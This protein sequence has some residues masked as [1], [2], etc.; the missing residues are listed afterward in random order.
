MGMTVQCQF[1]LIEVNAVENESAITCRRVKYVFI[2][3]I[4][5]G[6]PILDRAKVSTIGSSVRQFFGRAH[7]GLQVNTLEEMTKEKI[8]KELNRSCGAHAPNEYIFDI[9]AED[10]E[11]KGDHITE[12]E[13]NEVTFESLWEEFKKQNSPLN[14]ILFQLAKDESLQVFGYGEKGVTE[15]VEKLDENEVLYG[16]FRVV[17]V[18][19]EGT[20]TSIRERFVFLIWVPENSPVFARARVAMHKAVL[21]KRLETY[22]AEIRAEEKGDITK[23]GLVKLLDNTCGSHKPQKYIFAPGDEVACNN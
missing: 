23:E 6:T 5:L 19:Q 12:I 3:W 16:I 22:H 20:C 11:F 15:M 21:L 8:I 13:K 14:W 18:N 1:A 10:I 7:I 4:G 2:A 17:G 9:T